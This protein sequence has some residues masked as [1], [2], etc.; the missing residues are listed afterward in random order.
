MD[1]SVFQAVVV[2][3][4]GV[5]HTALLAISTPDDEFNFYSELFELKNDRGG[6]LFKTI[7]IGL[8]CEACQANGLRCEHLNHR[9]PHCNTLRNKNTHPR[10]RQ[11]QTRIY[12]HILT[13]CRN[14]RTRANMSTLR[15]VTEVQFSEMTIEDHLDDSDAISTDWVCL[16]LCDADGSLCDTTGKTV[17]RQELV[18]TILATNPDLADRESRGIVKSSRRHLFDKLWVLALGKRPFYT[19]DYRPSVLWMAIDPAGYITAHLQTRHSV[20]LPIACYFLLS[21]C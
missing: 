15:V 21:V 9:L 10:R 5:R 2:P 18:N 17:E 3:L 8:A 19:F 11:T 16:E 12:A 13:R 4:L 20:L 14:T 6:E 7:R 1:Q